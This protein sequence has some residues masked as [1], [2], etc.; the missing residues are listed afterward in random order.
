MS[1]GVIKQALATVVAGRELSTEMARTA[2]DEIM[3]G[4]A[5]AAQIGGL[6]AALRTKGESVDE[7][8][9][10]VQSMREHAT[11][12]LLQVDAVD[13][14]GTGGDGT[15]TFNIST[16]AALVAAGAGAPVAKHGN[17]AA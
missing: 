8:V 14:C 11:T 7:I 3:D 4:A 5:T 17:R 6:L 10:M 1:D 13:T 15:G 12:V 9:G 2:M 16:A